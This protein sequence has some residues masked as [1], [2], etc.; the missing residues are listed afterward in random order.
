M[1]R[2]KIIILSIVVLF[3]VVLLV[4]LN[5]NNLVF[6]SSADKQ[7]IMDILEITD[8]ESFK[9]IKLEHLNTGFG[10]AAEI[11]KLKF[12]ISKID[13][14]RNDLEYETVDSEKDIQ[15]VDYSC[16]KDLGNDYYECYIGRSDI[17]NEDDYNILSS[18]DTAS[19]LNNLIILGILIILLYML[20]N[21]K[22]KK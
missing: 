5:N 11:M 7:K 3:L 22:I 19:L 21:I 20:K 16:K 1:K 12:R 8:V 17:E 14:E 2:G 18:I 4:L 6:I 9:P 13:Y 10:S 15:Y